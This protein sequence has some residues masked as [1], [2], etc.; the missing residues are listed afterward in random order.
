MNL[1]PFLAVSVIRRSVA[2]QDNQRR[3][4]PRATNPSKKTLLYHLNVHIIKRSKNYCYCIFI[5]KFVI[6]SV[7]EI[8]ASVKSNRQDRKLGTRRFG[9]KISRR[10]GKFFMYYYLGIIPYYL[11]FVFGFLQAG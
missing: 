11:G 3:A 10:S 2:E 9:E 8:D 4:G 6:E 5:K 1:L 7:I